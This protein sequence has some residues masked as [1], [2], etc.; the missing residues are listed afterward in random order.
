MA[1]L[2]ARATELRNEFL[3]E[4]SANDLEVCVRVFDKIMS[5]TPA[6]GGKA[7]KHEKT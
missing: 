5:V 6:A 7:T 1:D 3:A 4:I 2:R